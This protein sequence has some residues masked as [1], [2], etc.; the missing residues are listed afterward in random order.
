[1]SVRLLGA[2]VLGAAG[3]VWLKRWR[4]AVVNPMSRT[5]RQILT[6]EALA[7][8]RADLRRLRGYRHRV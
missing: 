5:W 1:M 2:V 3:K 4:E 7:L 6:V 8:S